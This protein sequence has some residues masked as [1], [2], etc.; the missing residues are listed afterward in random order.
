MKT[1]IISILLLIPVLINAQ[2]SWSVVIDDNNCNKS[3]VTDYGLLNDSVVLVSGIASNASC[4]FH[5]LYAYD[6]HGNRLWESGGLFDAMYTDG[7]YVYTAGIFFVDDVM[8]TEHI[9]VAKFDKEG[10]EV[11]N[12]IWP[13]AY[14]YELY[15]PNP[16]VSIDVSANGMILIASE[17]YIV[18]NDSLGKFL[19]WKE[20]PYKTSIS[21]AFWQ[22]DTTWLIM[23]QSAIY[24]TDTTFRIMDSLHFANNIRD[25]KFFRDTLYCLFENE[26]VRIDTS[27]SLID[28]LLSGTVSNYEAINFYN[29][30]LWVQSSTA[31]KIHLNKIQ[32]HSGSKSLTFDMLFSVHR[33]IVADS[34]YVFI[35]NSPSQQMGIY[36]YNIAASGT[37]KIVLPDIE[38][39][40]FDIDSIVLDY[41]YYPDDTFAVG[42]NFITDITIGNKGNDTVNSFALFLDLYGG[43]NCSQNFFYKKFDDLTLLPDQ[44][45]ILKLPR[46]Y[47][48]GIEN[49]QLCFEIL[50]P[51]SM[52]ETNISNN[53]LCKTFTITGIR[54]H[55]NPSLKIFPNP[56]FDELT[57]ENSEN[58]IKSLAIYDLYGK[59]VMNRTYSSQILKLNLKDLPAGIYVVQLKYDDRQVRR[60]IIKR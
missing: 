46:I 36:N 20:W 21:N 39:V 45:I 59:Q 38:L 24:Q 52:V 1:F 13:A 53:T 5:K 32:K 10:N 58:R 47:Q 17:N 55:S 49:N 23:S 16:L 7:K 12:T 56:V 34:N 35:G 33:F 60:A 54:E 40:D 26:L 18:K 8:G 50:A 6:L 27:L 22:N 44:E 15:F 42:Y 41:V 37:P 25:T 29:D 28:T 3:E 2:T 9:G 48:Y 31:E 43:T 51:N 11:F 57:I 30:N 14:H 4:T 19:Y